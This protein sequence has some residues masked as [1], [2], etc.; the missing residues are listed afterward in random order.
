MQQAF[1]REGIA[2]R[3]NATNI[4]VKQSA[5]EKLIYFQTQGKEEAL[6]VDEILIGTGRAPN[7]LGLNLHAVGVQYDRCKGVLVNDRLQTTNPHIYAA[8]DVCLDWKFTHAADSSAR[9]VIQNNGS[10]RVIY[11]SGDESR[12]KT[13]LE[14]YKENETTL[15][16]QL[17]SLGVTP[18]Q[19]SADNIKV[20]VEAPSIWEG[21]LG[22]FVV[23][24]LPILLMLGVFWFIFRQAQGSNNAAMSFGKSRAR[25]FHST[26][27]A[28]HAAAAARRARTERSQIFVRVDPRTVTI[29]PDKLDSVIADGVD[30]L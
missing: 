23:Y 18:D 21:A 8:G 30:A 28:L 7:V 13:G 29:V 3:L 16:E 11:K 27:K 2:L 24:L 20:E 12:T 14:A 25:M 26:A 1:I 22:G 9:I 6:A 5:G 15:V 17:L 10:L 19:L 4:R